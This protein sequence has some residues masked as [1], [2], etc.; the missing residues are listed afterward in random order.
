MCATTLT[1]PSVWQCG[2][3]ARCG[4]GPRTGCREGRRAGRCVPMHCAESWRTHC[5]ARPCSGTRT[6]KACMRAHSAA[7][8]RMRGLGV[9]CTATLLG[10]G[11]RRATGAANR[12]IRQCA[13]TRA[14]PHGHRT[15]ARWPWTPM[16]WCGDQLS[17]MCRSHGMVRS[18]LAAGLAKRVAGGGVGCAGT[19]GGRPHA[20]TPGS[21]GVCGV[22]ACRHTAWRA[23]CNF[24]CHVR[25]SIVVSI[26]A[27]HADDPGS[28][29][30]RGDVM[31]RCGAATQARRVAAPQ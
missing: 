6:L 2:C 28:I 26:S 25:G 23:R 20:A 13:R 17:V 16:V 7:L 21:G 12:R 24:G 18:C 31:P 3:A 4:S 29:P 14:P 15:A 1:A 10:S 11:T 19:A 5:G 22:M 27:R 30:G 8:K 9:V